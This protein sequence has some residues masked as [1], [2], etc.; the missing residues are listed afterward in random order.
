MKTNS[1]FLDRKLSVVFFLLL[2]S[3]MAT[4]RYFDA[5]LKNDISP[6]GIVSFEFAKELPVSKAILNSWDDHAKSSAGMSL[7]F[8][9]LFLF[10]YAS[11]IA[12]LIL[13]INNRLWKNR[14]FYNLGRFLIYAIFIAA[15]FDVVENIALI[16]LML[17]DFNQFWSSIAYYFATFKFAIVIVCILYLLL[18]WIGLLVKKVIK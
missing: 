12:L 13:R 14:S 2:I 6:N 17:R 8:D 16:K 5:P 7:G 15:L 3:C 18:N 4:M 9:F 11:C 10:V 1:L